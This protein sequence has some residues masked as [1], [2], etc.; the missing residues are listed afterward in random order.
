M[1]NSVCVAVCASCLQRPEV[2]SRYHSSGDASLDFSESLTSR[3]FD[4]SDW[5]ASPREPPISVPQILRNAAGL[6]FVCWSLREYWGL[7]SSP[8]AC[9]EST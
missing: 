2:S 5:S 7:N 8:C 6:S 4:E 3:Q 9:M 1:V